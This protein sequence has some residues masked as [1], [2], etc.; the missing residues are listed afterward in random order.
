MHPIPLTKVRNS[1]FQNT[2]KSISCGGRECKWLWQWLQ[3]RLSND[4][5][6]RFNVTNTQKLGIG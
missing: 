4:E 3:I 1:E 5:S 6:A 2:N